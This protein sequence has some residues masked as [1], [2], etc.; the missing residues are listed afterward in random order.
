MIAA[1]TPVQG[2]LTKVLRTRAAPLRVAFFES[3]DSAFVVLWKTIYLLIPSHL[4]HNIKDI[5][6]LTNTIVSYILVL[7]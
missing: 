1:A 3:E 4:A 5:I 6:V 7:Q 2:I